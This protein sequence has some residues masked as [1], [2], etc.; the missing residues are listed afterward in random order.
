[1]WFVFFLIL[2]SL[3]AEALVEV[4]F[5]EVKLRDGSV[6]QL[7]KDGRFAH[8]AIKIENGWLHSHPRKGVEFNS[9]LEEIGDAKEIL[10]NESI[11]DFSFTEIEHLV[12]LPYDYAFDWNDPLSS[13]CSKLVALLLGINPTPMKFEG[14]YWEKFKKHK[15][16]GLPGVSPD[17]LYRELKKLGYQSRA[18]R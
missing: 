17:G 3:R 13:Y 1:M 10:S 18:V 6:L 14:P 9:T 8:V 11:A 16:E 2:T 7:E 4:A 12:G 5:F 15:A